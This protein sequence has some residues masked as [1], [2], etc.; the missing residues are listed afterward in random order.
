MGTNTTGSARTAPK[1]RA[2]RP[3]NADTSGARW[4]NST[5]QR[6][7]VMLAGLAILGAII[8]FGSDIGDDI[9]GDQGGPLPSPAATVG[10]IDPAA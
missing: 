7:L 2:T 5:A 4:L 10:S 1:G 8:W 3:R 9:G 6:I